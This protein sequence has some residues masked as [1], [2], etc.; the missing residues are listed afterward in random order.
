MMVWGSIPAWAGKPTHHPT[1]TLRTA[2]Y[3][4]VGGETV[5]AVSVA[6]IALG[7]S[8]RGRGNPLSGAC[9]QRRQGSIPAWAGKPAP[10]TGR[11]RAHRVYPRVG[12]E[13]QRAGILRVHIEGLSPRGRGNPSVRTPVRTA[14]GSIPAWAGKPV[15]TRPAFSSTRVYPRVGGETLR[16]CWYLDTNRGL[17]PRGRGNRSPPGRRFLR[18]GSIPAWAGKPFAAAGTSIP[19]EVYPRVGGETAGDASDGS[20]GGGLSPRGRG[21]RSPCASS[22]HQARSIPA[23]AGKPQGTCACCQHP[24]VYP[25]VGGETAFTRMLPCPAAGLSP[26]GRGNRLVNGVIRSVVRSIPAWAGKPPDGSTDRSPSAVYPRVGGE[27]VNVVHTAAPSSGLSPRGRGNLPQ[28]DDRYL[29]LGSIP[30]WAG[31][32]PTALACAREGTVYPRVGGETQA[33]TLAA[34]LM[35]GLSPRGRGNLRTSLDQAIS[36]WSIPAWA[37]KP[38]ERRLAMPIRAVYPRVGGETLEKRYLHANSGGLSPRGRGNLPNVRSS[39]RQSRSIPAWAGKPQES[40]PCVVGTGVYPR[41]GG[42]TTR[43][44]GPT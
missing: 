9:R 21:N 22:A 3:P 35:R 41:V 30:A 40:V 36:P 19:T 25:R 44:N 23:W 10:G 15:T 42:E 7:L 26:R 17:S 14:P 4:R 28:R 37:G 8:P 39:E 34:E 27:T 13:T 32:P 12:G 20:A 16:C 18:R 31:K 38:N 24:Q 6:F 1:T 43:A 29:R 11:R 33:D 5:G 2:V